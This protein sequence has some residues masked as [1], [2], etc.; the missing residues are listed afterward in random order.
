M[1]KFKINIS[2]LVMAFFTITIIFSS[3]KSKKKVND[4]PPQV[5]EIRN[6]QGRVVEEQRKD[7]DVDN[8]GDGI[9]NEKDNCPDEKGSSANNGCPEKV[10]QAFNFKNIQFEFNSSVLKTSSYAILDTIAQQMKQTPD[11][12]F[13][14]EGHSSSEG[15]EQRNMMLSVDRA[16]AVKAYLV[17]NGIKNA[18]LMTKGFGES[19]PLVSNTSESNKALNRRVE[20]KPL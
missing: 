10:V 7:V 14:L 8:D 11:A 4:L 12:K 19:K 17:N 2:F 5:E 16:N 15:T 6:E 20:I 9:P 3:C 13:Q 1:N 18:N